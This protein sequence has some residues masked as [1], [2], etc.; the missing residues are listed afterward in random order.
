M[1]S[2]SLCIRIMLSYT[3]AHKCYST[4]QQIW[5]TM[6]RVELSFYTGRSPSSSESTTPEA[7]TP[8]ANPPSLQPIKEGCCQ[9]SHL[10]SLPRTKVG[11]GA[12]PVRSSS[13]VESTALWLLWVSVLAVLSGT[14]LIHDKILLALYNKVIYSL[15][16]CSIWNHGWNTGTIS[17]KSMVTMFEG[18][19]YLLWAGLQKEGPTCSLR[20]IMWC[21]YG[22]LCISCPVIP[23]IRQAVMSVTDDVCCVSVKRLPWKLVC[24]KYFT[25]YRNHLLYLC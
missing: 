7:L 25:D 5:N 15:S 16:L 14:S 19:L 18:E 4:L 11:G 23:F 22:A 21:W 20:F 9:Q 2:L 1:K 13:P 8:S 24:C 6:C 12:T 10:V 3:V 17:L